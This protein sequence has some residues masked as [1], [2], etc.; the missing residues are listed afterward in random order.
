MRRRMWPYSQSQACVALLFVGLSVFGCSADDPESQQTPTQPPPPLTQLPGLPAGWFGGASVPG[1]FEI[2]RDL[3][4]KRTGGASA[5]LRSV[6]SGPSSGSFAAL[7]HLVRADFYRGK[8]VRWSGFIRTTDVGAKGAALWLR[9]DGANSSVAFDNMGN[10]VRAGTGDWTYAEVI[11]DMPQDV[12][13]MA[14]G[15]LLSDLGTAWLDDLK[16]EVVGNDVPVTANPLN[17]PYPIADPAANVA[18][19]SRQNFVPLNLDFEGIVYPEMQPE[20]VAWLRSNSISFLTEDANAPDDDLRPFRDMIGSARLVGLGEG[21]HGTREFFR[22]KHR[23][24][25]FL[26]RNLGFN[27]FSIE[28]SLPE[29][30]AVDQYV[31]TGRGDVPSLVRGM[32][33][34]TWST[35][36]VY[37]LVRWMRAWNESGGQPRVHFTGFDMQYPAVAMDSVYAF[38]NDIDQ[39]L[40]DTVRTAYAC[41]TPY[42]TSGLESYRALPRETKDSCR[43]N[44]A[45]VDSLFARRL[46]SWSATSGAART[47]LAQRSARVVSQWEDHAQVATMSETIA[48]RD[49]YMAENIAWWRQRLGNAGMV[50]WA[51]NGHVARNGIAMGG[52]LARQFGTDYVNVGQT[53]SA[54]SFNAYGQGANGVITSLLQHTI[55]GAQSGSIEAVFTA[56]GLAKAFVDARKTMTGGPAAGAL[57]RTLSI[58]SIGSVYNAATIVSTAALALPEDYDIIVWFQ[59]TNA[60]RLS[61]S[62]AATRELR[63]P[64]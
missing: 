16:L 2:G 53:F 31:Q 51:H 21:T 15:A 8:R 22:M 11:L 34:W 35:E 24:F 64:Y 59:N 41:L 42:R 54:G 56:T 13:G 19:Y 30:L 4:I 14:F 18:H 47:T 61:L 55:A 44:L 25:A 38:V 27:Q 6:T 62:L 1:E 17:P 58:R 28:A 49:R 32:R 45:S 43:A 57:R 46:T 52:H 26:V 50:A 48:A 7:T 36:E 63:E 3:A 37:D 10:R 39:S 12:V 23:M 29:A 5:Y 20:S 9:G 40:A 33:F 60:S